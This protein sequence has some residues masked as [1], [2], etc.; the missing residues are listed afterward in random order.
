MLFPQTS[1]TRYNLK[2]MFHP[3]IPLTAALHRSGLIV[4]SL[5]LHAGLSPWLPHSH[6]PRFRSR[7][8][9]LYPEAET[10]LSPTHLLQEPTALSPLH[11]DP[12]SP[13]LSPF[14]TGCYSKSTVFTSACPCFRTAHG[15]PQ[16]LNKYVNNKQEKQENY[17]HTFQLALTKQ[18][19][20][21]IRYS[22]SNYFMPNSVLSFNTHVI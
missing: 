6:V 8:C 13:P 17:G 12:C 16:S 15:M 5:Y 19:F 22:L 21:I 11:Q 9:P 4:R 3:Y 2:K 20:Q 18:T 1:N 7:S 14:W 10:R